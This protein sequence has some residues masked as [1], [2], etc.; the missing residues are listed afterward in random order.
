[1]HLTWDEDMAYT[2]LLRAYYRR[3]KPIGA[4]EAHRIARATTRG[5][6]QAVDRVLAEFFDQQVDGWH[7]KRADEEIQRYQAQSTTNRRIAVARY[8]HE[9]SQDRQPNQNQIPEPD[10]RKEV[11]PKV[12]GSAQAPFL[13]PDWI[14]VDQWNA[15]VEARKKSR[16]A[17]TKFAMQLAVAKLDELRK[18]GHHPAAVLAQSAFNGWAGLFELKGRQ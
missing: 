11:K 13:L 18:E 3:E 5:Q 15:W 17:P 6:K 2:R 10:T 4:D 9:P 7:N 12:N 14:P 8:G 1:M 16:K